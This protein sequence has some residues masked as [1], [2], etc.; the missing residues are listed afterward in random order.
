MTTPD[1]DPT[2]PEVVQRFLAAG[3]KLE[4]IRLDA[5]GTWW[6]RGALFE[7]PKLIHLFHGSVGRTEGGTWVLEI[8]PFTYPIEVEDTGF[9]VKRLE[10][11]EDGE[12]VRL[13]LLG[14][15]V[16][17]LDPDTLVADDRG[18]TCR[19][20]QGRFRARLT[21]GAYYA[22]TEHVTEEGGDFLLSLGDRRWTIAADGA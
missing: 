12:R 5:E 22:L 17:E 3:A 4:S 2:L 20:K 18:M 6:H 7:N 8:P 15:A 16:E 13:H 11:D 1:I 21:R 14:G 19:I 10:F 9:F